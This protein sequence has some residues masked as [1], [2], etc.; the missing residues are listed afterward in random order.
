MLVNSVSFFSDAKSLKLTFHKSCWCCHTL[1][2]IMW[3]LYIWDNI[4]NNI[5]SLMCSYIKNVPTFW[6]KQDECWNFSKN[7]S[8]YKFLSKWSMDFFQWMKQNNEF[9]LIIM[10]K[11]HSWE[12]MKRLSSSK[13]CKKSVLMQWISPF[14]KQPRTI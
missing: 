3:N 5:Y 11:C 2:Y 6:S 12:E 4:M 10:R 7:R 14:S 9:L 13:T 8:L 1:F